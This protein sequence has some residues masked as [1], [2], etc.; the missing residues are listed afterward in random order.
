MRGKGKGEF[1]IADSASR[2]KPDVICKKKQKKQ[3]KGN[4]CSSECKNIVKQVKEF[5]FVGTVDETGNLL[6]DLTDA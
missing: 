1:C 4:I 6:W 2:T 3:R 5:F